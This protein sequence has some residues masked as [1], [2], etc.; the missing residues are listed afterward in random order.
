MT[1]IVRKSERFS[2]SCFFLWGEGGG[3]VIAFVDLRL[4]FR[5]SNQQFPKSLNV[6]IYAPLLAELF[7][8][9]TT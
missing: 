4:K 2:L 9:I 5:T 8:Q 7:K 6:D 1:D 3:A